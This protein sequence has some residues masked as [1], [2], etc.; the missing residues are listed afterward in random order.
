MF[1]DALRHAANK[2][3]IPNFRHHQEDAIRRFIDGHDV[4]VALPTNYGKSKIYQG[5]PL[6]QDFLKGSVKQQAIAL[7]VSPIN[8]I[9]EQQVHEM[10]S[11]GIPAL[12]LQVGLNWARDSASIA[13]GKYSILFGS[14]ETFANSSTKDLLASSDIRTNI[15]GIFVDES[16]CI[17]QW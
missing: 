11:K 13:S 3:K 6:C 8:A 5:I 2:L 16:H 9:I 4:F 7:V 17:E 12:H 1:D 14:P 15:C 10:N